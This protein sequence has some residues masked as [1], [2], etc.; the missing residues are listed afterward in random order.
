MKPRL[1]AVEL[2]GL[3]DQVFATPFLQGA[4]QWFEVSFLGRPYASELQPRFWPEVEVVPF[5]APWT[6]H[7]GKYRLHRWPWKTF[8]QVARDLRRRQFDIAVSGRWDPRDHVLLFLSGAKRRLGYARAGSQWLL[9]EP[10]DNPGALAHRCEFWRRAADALQFTL[11]RREQL[12][13][14]S[15]TGPPLV[16]V[17]T[18]AAREVRVWPLSRYAQLVARLRQ[19]GC[20]VQV[21]CDSAQRSWWLGQGEHSVETPPT[22]TALMDSLARGRV[23]VGNDSGPGHLAAILGLP[24]LTLFGPQVSQGYLPMHPAAEW[25]DGKECPFKGCFDYCR[26]AAPHCL[27]NVTL[28]EVWNKA[29]AFVS[30]HLGQG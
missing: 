11:P 30:R 29:S 22:V 3:G 5:T 17:H 18:G 9:T 19:R 2:W 14:A 13:V 1:L 26:Y 7:R 20:Q 6:A 21:I 8:F 10:L 28:D 27:Q 25:V 12:M 16:I 15:R 24:T 23:F 4:A